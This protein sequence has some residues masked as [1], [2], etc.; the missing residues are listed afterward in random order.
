MH[1]QVSAILLFISVL[2]LI[3]M[4]LTLNRSKSKK[5]LVK[6]FSAIFILMLLWDI[7][8]IVQ[9]VAVY[10]LKAELSP[11]YFDYITYIGIIFLPVFLYL[12]AKAFSN[13]KFRVK[14]YH[15]LLFMIPILSA[16]VL[17][18][19]D[20]HHLFYTNYSLY[21]SE[22]T[23]GPYFYIHT[24]YTYT[25]IIISLVILLKN[26]IKQSNK[27]SSQS[28]LFLLAIAIP[29]LVNVVG[30]LGLVELSIYTTPITFSISV[31]LLFIAIFKFNFLNLNTIALQVIVNTISDSYLVIDNDNIITNCNKS[32]LKTFNIEKEN[33]V[34]KDIF[35]L[36]VYSKT[37]LNDL[38][39]AFELIK[40]KK[41]KITIDKHFEEMDKY[42]SIDISPILKN[43]SYLGTLVFLRDVTEKEHDK[44]K[45]KANQDLLIEQERLASLGQMIGGIAHNLKTPIFSI[46]GG[47]EGLSDLIKEYDESIEDPSVTNKDMH[48]IAKDMNEW[49]VK[50]KEHISY[51]SEVITTVKGQAVTMSEEQNVVFPISELFQ[52]VTILMQHELKEKLAVL[53][54]QN[55]IPDDI[56]IDGNINSLVQVINNLIS[57]SIEAYE[58]YN[59]E[60]VID[61]S[62]DYDNENDI[63]ILSVKDYG[64]GLPDSVKDK[65]FKEMVTTKGKDGTGLGLFMSYSNIKAH[66]SGNL[67]FTTKPNNGTTFYISI[68]RK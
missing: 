14:N 63:I 18:T 54:V 6:L 5:L 33:L 28:I 56:T 53:N 50:L 67:T 49:I 3:Y 68:P 59:K 40:L 65:L 7:S 9:Y 60:K 38:Q 26:S 43:D 36:N 11:I 2:F 34:N 19:N 21:L 51:M 25:L 57:N 22:S 12:S 13:S 66:F 4:M 64:P 15:K 24:V 16:I 52:H 62:A 10:F 17:W 55:N 48:D 44:L 37:T 30:M 35:E 23:Y 31:A 46:A 1:S 8:L 20:L 47:L 42:F 39:V 45:I 29:V 58:N 41:S 61:L 32:F 27:I